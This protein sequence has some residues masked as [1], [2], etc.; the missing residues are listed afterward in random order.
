MKAWLLCIGIVVA[1]GGSCKDEVHHD[2][3]NAVAPS[4][5]HGG[6]APRELLVGRALASLLQARQAYGNEYDGVIVELLAA[7]C[8]GVPLPSGMQ[9]K[10]ETIEAF[11]PMQQ[12]P[13]AEY[14]FC[15]SI[16]LADG[17]PVVAPGFPDH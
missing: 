17:R 8:K 12:L 10:R 9:V 7:Q 13:L 11:F 3:Q 6:A 14:A 5:G 1:T 16:W 2:S 4:G 15:G